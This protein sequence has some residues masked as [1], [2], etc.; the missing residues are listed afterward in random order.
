MLSSICFCIFQVKKN[1]F[2]LNFFKTST[3]KYVINRKGWSHLC[4]HLCKS[5]QGHDVTI[6]TTS[7][8]PA[9]LF[10]IS[11]MS[12]SGRRTFK[13]PSA[14]TLGALKYPP[15]VFENGIS[16]RGPRGV[17]I[18]RMKYYHHPD[19]QWTWKALQE[20]IAALLQLAAK[21]AD[22]VSLDLDIWSQT[23]R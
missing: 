10:F 17:T 7:V 22:T 3:K 2:S 9:P 16:E 19:Q 11:T 4:H 14:L 5:L 6:L 18:L 12:V 13:T 23:P 8:T 20:D 21:R 1:T 15:P